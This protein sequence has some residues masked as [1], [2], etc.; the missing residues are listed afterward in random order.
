MRIVATAFNDLPVAE[1]TI[2]K[3]LGEKGELLVIPLPFYSLE[4]EEKP[5]WFQKLI[6]ADAL[7]VRSGIVDKWLIDQLVNCKVISL[8]GVGVDQVD[9][10]YC[11]VKGITVTNAPGG[12]ANAA[13]ELTVGLMLDALRGISSAHN[14]LLEKKWDEGKKIGNELGSQKVGIIGMG[15][16]GQ[17]VAQLCSAFGSEV[18]YFDKYSEQSAYKKFDLDGLLKWA[19][20]ITIHVPL[21]NE[22]KSLINYKELQLLGEEGILVNVA[23]GAI[24]NE[25]DLARALKDNVI[26]WAACDVFDGE[27]PN[28]KNDLFNNNNLTMTPHIGGSTYECLDTIANIAINDII[29]VLEDKAPKFRV[30]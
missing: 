13:A 29:R 5:I 30:V 15:H 3:V 18:A 17:K 28:F 25:N 27:P 9:V 4:N 26:K 23:R 14:A 20:I 2:R 19:D 8:H 6:S 7:F 21:N 24:I 10:E 1:D 12:N 16:I 22:T 11:K